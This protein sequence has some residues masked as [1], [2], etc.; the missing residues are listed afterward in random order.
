MQQ[1]LPGPSQE[2]QLQA[3][4]RRCRKGFVGVTLFSA[5]ANLL[6]LVAPV[7]MLQMYDRVLTSASF[8]TLIVLTVVAVFLLS[9][10]GLLDWVRQRL[11]ARI[12]LSLN[13]E[14]LDDVLAGVFRGSL[15]R[16]RQSADQPMRDLDT[17]RQFI[18]SPPA[19]AF[20]D[21]PWAPIFI[22]A[23]YLIHPWLG[24]FAIF[25]ALYILFLAL[26]TEWTSRGP[27][28]NASE[29][30]AESHRF[31]ESSLRNSDVLEAMGM[32]EGFRRRWRDKHDRS[33]AF[34]A[35]GGSRVSMLLS[36]SKSGRQ[37]VQVGILGLGAWLV[38]EQQ[39]SPGMMIAASI[40]LGRALAPIEQGISAWRGFM[41]ARQGWRRLN[42]LLRSA[43]PTDHGGATSL[44]RPAGK[45][46]VEGVSAAPPGSTKLTVRQVR[47]TLEP[48]SGTGLI[49]PSGSGK[50]TLARLMV[51]VWIPQGGVVRL[52]GA[53]VSD[54]P[55]ESRLR[56][57][58]YLPQEVE[59][60]EGTV[61]ENIARLTEPDDEAV[62]AA[63]QQASC[64]DMVMRLPENYN[65]L[66]AAGGANLS[67]GQRQRVA[68]ARALYGDPALVVLDEPD[69]NLDTDGENALRN[70][71]AMLAK[72]GVTTLVVTH[73]FRLLRMVENVLVLKEGMLLESG[74]RDEVLKRFMRPAPALP[75]D[76]QAQAG[77]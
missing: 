68:L 9:C 46:E 50:S 12:A 71:L 14:V 38:L 25:A 73:N 35:R 60:F 1:K 16:F 20:F 21:A 41:S 4:M 37:I 49:G 77:T 40:I 44:P 15:Q 33:V 34:Q 69:A 55:A 3:A 6:M 2:T 22:A 47:F 43:P 11:M 31:V 67:A 53:A 39:I 23:I 70:T 63:A 74:P 64:H 30:T 57:V 62:I 72:R 18:S 5:M 65:T 32:F 26:L 52:D 24:S 75:G 76:K 42:N 45:L 17:V 54:W 36:A 59:L 29:H 10:F 27:F 19:L 58:G 56:H 66:I 48:G 7:Y 13:Y 61:A 8:E 51:G 28:R